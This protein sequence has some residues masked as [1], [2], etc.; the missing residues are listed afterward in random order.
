MIAIDQT[1]DHDLVDVRVFSVIFRFS[2]CRSGAHKILPPQSHHPLCS[3]DR[4][5]APVLQHILY[6]SYTALLKLP[7]V[8]TSKIRKS[9]STKLTYAHDTWHIHTH[10]HTYTSF[11]SV[12]NTPKWRRLNLFFFPLYKPRR[13]NPVIRGTSPISWQNDK[14]W[15]FFHMS[16]L[17][18]HT[19][20]WIGNFWHNSTTFFLLLPVWTIKQKRDFE[21]GGFD[22]P[23]TQRERFYCQPIHLYQDQV[24]LTS[25]VNNQD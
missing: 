1:R 16:T 12:P 24:S 20:E 10:V 2:V 13:K 6:P 21:I 25:L 14:A 15:I 3:V 11:F 17:N 22:R 23:H 5:T 18:T 7:A 4:A 19:H 9:T 8:I